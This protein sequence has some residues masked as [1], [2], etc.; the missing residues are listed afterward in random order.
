MKDEGKGNTSGIKAG[1]TERLQ[2]REPFTSLKTALQL[3]KSHYSVFMYRIS[4]II[5]G[6]WKKKQL[7]VKGQ[8][9]WC[10]WGPTGEEVRKK[11]EGIQNNNSDSITNREAL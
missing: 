3:H 2:G 5:K 1:E 9:G 10:L 7:E 4:L 11:M 8:F 6:A